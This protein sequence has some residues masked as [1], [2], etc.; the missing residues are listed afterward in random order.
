MPHS[1]AGEL[2]GTRPGRTAFSTD[3]EYHSDYFTCKLNSFAL[4]L[5]IMTLR[6][7]EPPSESAECVCSKK[8]SRSHALA[9]RTVMHMLTER[10]AFQNLP[11]PQ[12][13]DV[14]NWF[15]DP[16]HRLFFPA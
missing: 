14:Q 15:T 13:P 3:N 4:S 2:L 6:M 12:F 7:A 5:R 9:E 1:Q 10:P 11:P 16:A 8:L